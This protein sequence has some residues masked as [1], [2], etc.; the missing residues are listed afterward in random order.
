[1][2]DYSILEQTAGKYG[3]VVL[4]NEPMKNHTSFRIGG[5][6]DVMIKINCEA[7]LCELIKQCRENDIKY[8]VVGREAISLSVTRGF[9]ELYCL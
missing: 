5:P 3:A 2:N 8:Y 6:C 9:R 4:K 1:M 7:L